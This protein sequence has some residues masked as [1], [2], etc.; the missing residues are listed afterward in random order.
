MKN[1]K[2]YIQEFKDQFAVSGVVT[3]ILGL[4]L[5]IRRFADIAETRGYCGHNQQRDHRR[6]DD[7]PGISAFFK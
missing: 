3:F 1:I 7:P 4:L 2:K 5:I 6:N